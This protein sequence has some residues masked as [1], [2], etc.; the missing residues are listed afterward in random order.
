MSTGFLVLASRARCRP[1]TQRSSKQRARQARPSWRL[2]CPAGSTPTP[3]SR[4]VPR[5]VR[6]RQRRSLRSNLVFSPDRTTSCAASSRCTASTL[7]CDA[8]S[9]RGHRLDWPVARVEPARRPSSSRSQRAQGN[10]RHAR[11]RGRRHGNVRRTAPRRSCGAAR[12]G[13]QDLGRLCGADHPQV[14]GAQPELMLRTADNVLGAGASALV[15]GPGLGT[16]PAAAA[17]L[18]RAL[19]EPVPLVLDADALNLIAAK[20]RPRGGGRCA[21]GSHA[22][23]TPSRRGRALAA[24]IRV[25][26]SGG[27]ARVSACDRHAAPRR[28]RAERRGQRARASGRNLGRQRE[29]QSRRSRPRAR[30][31]C[32]PDSPVRSSRR[33]SMRRCRC[34]SPCACMAPRPMPA[35]RK[36]AAQWASRASELI[37]AARHLLNAA[38]ASMRSACNSVTE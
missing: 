2:T 38:A 21:F 23:H 12:G 26:S 27:S 7:T 1:I 4:V 8:T 37:L 10:V 13:G 22:R 35:S 14:D 5:F 33:A 11:H 29:R 28:G 31:T 19:K 6:P 24:Q 15:C 20:P 25:R 34:G 30:A 18:A 3:G 32:W 9:A 17:I 16:E 36:G